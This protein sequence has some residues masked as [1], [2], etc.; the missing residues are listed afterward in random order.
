MAANVQNN[1]E[2]VQYGENVTLR[3]I[4]DDDGDVYQLENK[5][6]SDFLERFYSIYEKKWNK[7]FKIL[8]R[9]SIS[10]VDIRGIKKYMPAELFFEKEKWIQWHILDEILK[11]DLLERFY[12]IYEKKW[13]KLFRIFVRRS[14]SI[15]DIGGKKKY[16]PAEL[17]FEKEKW[18][19][20]HIRD[21]ILKSDLF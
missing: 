10:I 19:Q 12:S 6:I 20:W 2:D 5:R 14:L 18:I 11:S 1:D 17:F 9:R 13:N 8:V 15:V 21:E 7:L 4:M 16:M 3:D